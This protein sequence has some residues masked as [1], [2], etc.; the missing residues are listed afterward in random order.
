MSL[1]Y[2]T[3]AVSPTKLLLPSL[4]VIQAQKKENEENVFL[5]ERCKDLEG[6]DEKMN[7]AEEH[8]RKYR[9]M[10][11][12]AYRKTMRERV[13]TKGRLVLKVAE[14]IRRGMAS[15]SKFAPKWEGSFLIR[16]ANASECYCLARMDES[17][18]M[19]PINGKWLK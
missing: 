8:G 7:E 2:G 15:P 12:G 10:M 17:D 14:H 19:D 5:A 11:V 4:R 3:E 6:L 9:K 18:L 1:V 16:E 13:F